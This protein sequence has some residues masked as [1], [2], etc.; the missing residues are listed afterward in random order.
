V[1]AGDVVMP[2]HIHL[3][4]SEAEGATASLVMQAWK[5][6]FGRRCPG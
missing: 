5:E 2:E 4:S 1:V 3:L 6:I